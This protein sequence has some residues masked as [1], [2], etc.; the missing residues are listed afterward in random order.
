MIVQTDLYRDVVEA[1]ARDLRVVF[2]A[3]DD[4]RAKA[5]L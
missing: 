1:S 3:I 2:P 5:K 4:I